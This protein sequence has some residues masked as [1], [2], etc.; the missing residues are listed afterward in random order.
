MAAAR[1]IAA[2]VADDELREDYIIPSVFN[3]DVAPAVAAA[4]AGE[5]RASG[6]RRG[7]RRRAR[8]RGGDRTS[9]LTA[10]AEPRASDGRSAEAHARSPS[11]APPG[12]SARA[13]SQALRGARRRG[14]RALARRR[15]GRRDAGRRGRRLGPRA[16]RRPRRRWP[17]AT[18]VVHLAGESVA[19]R[20][21]DGRQ[22]R[23]PREPEVGTRNLVAGLRA[24]DP[25]PGVLVSASA[26]GYY[27][28][29]GDEEIDE[30][31][32]PGDGLPR[33]RRAS[34]G[35]PRPRGG[36][37]RHARRHARAPASCSTRTAARWRGC[38]RP[39]GSASA[40][41]W[42]AG[43]SGCPGSTATTSSG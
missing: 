36:G 1:G 6:H 30:S 8:L 23:H 40:A 32:P 33:E 18:R 29:R 27:G 21:S 10:A 43:A 12:A 26:I 14:D 37:P 38:C 39:S 11:P 15:R 20:W 16:S 7:G 28:A 22:A 35:R 42:P 4:V 34:T 2:I 31:A 13:W 17:A 25:R 3:R 41:R 5:A 24:A 9:E 19:Q